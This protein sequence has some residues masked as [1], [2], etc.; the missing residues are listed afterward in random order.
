MKGSK[1][2]KELTSAIASVKVKDLGN[3]ATANFDQALAGRVSGLQVSSVDGTPG[4]AL[5]IVIRGGN[6]ITGDNSPLYV[7]DGI[8][9]EDF[10]PASIST[11][12]IASFD[13]LKDA[14]ATAIYGSRGANGIIIITTKGAF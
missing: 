14:S 3:T 8:P 12:D 7:I 5:N 4:A 11:D 2:K 13:V 9:L 1:N 6:S 10:D